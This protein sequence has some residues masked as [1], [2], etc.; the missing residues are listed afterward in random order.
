MCV[1]AFSSPF[2]DLAAIISKQHKNEL[3]K[4]ILKEL[5]LSGFSFYYYWIML[6]EFPRQRLGIPSFMEKCQ[7]E[8]ELL[9]LSKVLLQFF[10][11]LQHL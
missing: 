8:V 7:M 4:Q 9:I 5:F 2:R 6:F 11:L 3:R 10:I 1:Y